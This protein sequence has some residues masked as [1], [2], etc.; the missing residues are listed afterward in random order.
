MK[1]LIEKYRG[2]DIHFEVNDELFSVETDSYGKGSK[3]FAAVKSGIDEYLKNNLEFKPFKAIRKAGGQLIT[4]IGIRKDGRFNY[5]DSKGNKKQLSEYDEMD[6]V[7]YNGDEHD[8]HF[9]KSAY[10]ETISD[11]AKREIERHYAKLTGDTIKQIKAN[12][13]VK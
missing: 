4:I 7:I 6:Y 8:K 5:E 3:S 9:A 11:E 12:Y 10:L 1:V 13:I 2:F